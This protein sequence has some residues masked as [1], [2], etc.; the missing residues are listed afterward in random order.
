M[1]AG[2]QVTHPCRTCARWAGP[3]TERSGRW[4]DRLTQLRD[5]RVGYEAAELAR[6]DEELAGDARVLN[7]P[8]GGPPVQVWTRYPV[9]L[10]RRLDLDDV[11]THAGAITYAALLSIPPLALFAASVA[12]FVLAGRPEAQQTIL[13]ALTGILPDSLAG[14]ARDVVARQLSEAISGRLAIGLLG[15]IALLW[16][17]SGLAA[18]LRHAF[19]VI[20]GTAR[21]GILTGR[22]IGM[23]IGLIGIVAIFAPLVVSAVLAWAGDVTSRDVVLRAL[24]AL[25]LVLAEALMFFLV[26]VLLTP[27]RGPALR[28]HLF[29]VAAFVVG[30]E[31]LKFLGGWYFSAVVAK[32]TALYGALGTLFGAI[33]F[34]YV[35]VWLLLLGAE[36]TALRWRRH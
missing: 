1:P 25:G 10:F 24:G 18:R 21:A 32:S 27:G 22:P 31:G 4:R 8:D 30:F 12:G 9:L 13:D 5:R 34:L 6:H 26:Y 23:V 15:T 33:A 20:F 2:A 14:P 28:H 29:G 16:A 7:N 36:V 3:V 35:A 19:G 17:A 11:S